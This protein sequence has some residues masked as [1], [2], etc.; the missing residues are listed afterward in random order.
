MSLLRIYPAVD[1]G[2]GRGYNDGRLDDD[3]VQTFTDAGSIARELQAAGIRFER[4]HAGATLPADAP[5]E[6][7]LSAYQAQVDALKSEHGFV[8]ADVVSLGPT[9]PDRQALRQ[10]FLSEHT[11]SDFEVR[12]FVAGQGL[13]YIHHEDRVYAVLCQQN[14][15][16]SVPAGTRHWFDMGPQPSFTCIRLFNDPAGWVAEYTGSTIADYYPKFDQFSA[17]AA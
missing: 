6:A 13:F 17:V 15:L 5:A 1:D 8:T 12:F 2:E 16:I 10:K 14:D 11:H 9:H 7:I 3:T 4:W